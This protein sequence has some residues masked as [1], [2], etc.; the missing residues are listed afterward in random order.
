MHSIRPILALLVLGLALAWLPS[1]ASG[2]PP[3]PTELGEQALAS[4]DWRSA[5]THFAE[6]LRLD[7]RD[8]RAWLG[9]ARAQLAGRDPEASLRSL[10][11]LAKTDPD[12]FRGEAQGTYADSLDAVVRQRLGRSQNEAALQAVRVL[13]KLEPKRKGLPR[14]LGRTLVGEATRRRLMGER[15]PALALYREACEVTPGDLEA[16][17]G[18]AE[19][20]LETKKR[21]QTIRL[22]EAARTFHP[23]AGAI[24]TLSLQAMRIR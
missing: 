8:S 13:A 9:Q 19:I 6:A 5:K 3:T 7:D 10:S 23:T 21:K 18:A 16:W 14:L 2:P 22:L 15:K 24:R 17:I 4:G 1:C 20:L 12:R 11:S